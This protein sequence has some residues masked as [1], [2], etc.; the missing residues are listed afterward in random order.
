VD[1]DSIGTA[2]RAPSG[3]TFYCCV[4]FADF[5]LITHLTN[6]LR[7]RRAMKFSEMNVF[8]QGH[9]AR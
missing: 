5:A 7:P 2:L 9:T 1:E 8:A 4:V 3:V 6:T